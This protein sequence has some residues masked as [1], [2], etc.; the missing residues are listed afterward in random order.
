MSARV[1]SDG[2]SLEM[3]EKLFDL[4]DRVYSG[5]PWRMSV[6][7]VAPKGDRFL[8]MRD[9]EP[10]VATNRITKPNVQVVLNWFEEFREK[11]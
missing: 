1:K 3:P 10:I 9:V 8:M 6:M 11:K 5:N 7:D 4:P 2:K